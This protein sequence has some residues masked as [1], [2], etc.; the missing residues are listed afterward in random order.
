MGYAL[1]RVAGTIL[2][3]TALTARLVPRLRRWRRRDEAARLYARYREFT[4]VP[5]AAFADNLALCAEYARQAGPVIECGVWRGGMSAAMA[6]L[7]GPGHTYYL[8]DSFE[9][10]PPADPDK[11]G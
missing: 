8:F 6:E 10:L 5:P 1:N 2:S 11:D 4:M 3:S 7:L 9:G